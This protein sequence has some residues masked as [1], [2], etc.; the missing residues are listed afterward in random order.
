[1]KLSYEACRGA[2]WCGVREKRIIVGDET[3]WTEL[4]LKGE[5]GEQVSLGMTGEELERLCYQLL[6]ALDESRMRSG[7]ALPF[8]EPPEATV[9]AIKALVIK[10]MKDYPLP[11]GKCKND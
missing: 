3:G 8:A 11:E 1:M 9:A 10:H 4:S 7:P 2:W 6:E 5:H